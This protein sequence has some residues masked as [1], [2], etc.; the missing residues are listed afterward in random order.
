MVKAVGK[1][2]LG[3]LLGVIGIYLCVRYYPATDDG[4][5]AYLGVALALTGAACGV[6]V[7]VFIE[8][9][10]VAIGEAK[11]EDK[12][13]SEI[14]KQLARSVRKSKIWSVLTTGSLVLA[15]SS[16]LLFIYFLAKDSS[17]AGPMLLITA[18]MVG[19]FF[20]VDKLYNKYYWEPYLEKSRK[21][22]EDEKIAREREMQAEIRMVAETQRRVDEQ[23]KEHPHYAALKQIMETVIPLY[24]GMPCPKLRI[25]SFRLPGHEHAD[26]WWEDPY[27]YILEDFLKETKYYDW[28]G[29]VKHEL[30]HAWQAYFGFKLDDN[31]FMRGQKGHDTYFFWKALDVNVSVKDT[32]RRY[33]DSEAL[34]KAVTEGK[35]KGMTAE[36]MWNTTMPGKKRKVRNGWD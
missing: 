14:D 13:Q 5:N 35:F 36:Q 20:L 31:V 1:P 10:F 18:G 29:L 9:F 30:V 6:V 11:N 24:D 16:F 25:A 28:V 17:F 15:G 26:G 21:K 34:Y 8:R 22:R 19:L 7:I 2:I 12:K 33:P 4:I 23:Q 32:L 3:I 27:V